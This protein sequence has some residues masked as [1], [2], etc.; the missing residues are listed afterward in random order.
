MY[1]W[2]TGVCPF[3]GTTAEEI[4]MK[5]LFQAPAP[6]AGLLRKS[7]FGAD[8]AILAC[9]EKDP[10]KRIRDYS[11]L[12]LALAESAKNS[13]VHYQTFRPSLRHKMPMVGA[14]EFGRQIQP[15]RTGIWNKAGT[16]AWLN[17]SDV[18]PFLR[19]AE[20]LAGVGDFSKAADILGS[21]FVPESV[22]ALPDYPHNQHV[23]INY[24][25]CQIALGR[26][27]EA[28]KTLQCLAAAKEKPAEYFVSLSLAQISQCDHRYAASTASEGLRLYPGDQD[29]IGNLLTAQTATGAFADATETAK[30]RLAVKRDVHSLHEVAALHCRYAESVREMDWPLAVKNLRYAVSLLREA[31][32]LNPR[33]LPARMQLPITLEALTAYTQCSDEIGDTK[34][35]PLHIS[36]R[37]FLAYL[38][39][40]CLD[41]LNAHKQCCDFCDGWLKRIAEVQ[42]TNPMPRHNVVRLERVR[43]VTIADGY[44]IGHMQEGKRVMVREAYEF[45]SQIVHDAE[46]REAG[47][48]CY[49][50]RLHEWMEEYEKAHVVLTEAESLYPE[51]WEIPFNRAAFR[52]RAGDNSG[53]MNSADRAAQLAPW[54]AQSWRLLAK[55]LAG[56][57][58]VTEAESASRRAEEV[59]RVRDE[60]ADE[61]QKT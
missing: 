16:Y 6:I 30:T 7:A 38:I 57:G 52:M 44:C 61:I 21:L 2:E 32:E 12:D 28:I 10:D 29:L 9:L 55:A 37:V 20:A 43:A 39:A 31:K 33:F 59:Q 47:D 27:D 13:G 53:A 56:I 50:A 45:F 17:R 49:L 8:R 18:A 5:H 24:A 60:I 4:Q 15:G 48:F 51:F 11:S 14:G 46:L 58:K 25:N 40:R 19:E 1:E 26:A 41:G 36:D 3:T 22:T 34:A 35:L 54:K 42:A 23:A